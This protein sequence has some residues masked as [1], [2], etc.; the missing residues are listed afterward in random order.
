MREKALDEKTA[1]LRDMRR[2]KAWYVKML[3]PTILKE[4]YT[5]L[6]AK[7]FWRKLQ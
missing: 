2:A 1:E 6:K 3:A 4:M 7:M 5:R